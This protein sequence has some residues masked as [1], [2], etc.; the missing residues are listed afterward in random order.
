MANSRGVEVVVEQL[1]HGGD[2][3]GRE[4]TQVGVGRLGRQLEVLQVAL[5]GGLRRQ[6]REVC[7]CVVI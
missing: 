1:V 4:G 3:F 2:V 6:R 7:L 5:H